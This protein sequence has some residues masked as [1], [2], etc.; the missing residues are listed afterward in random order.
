[1]PENKKLVIIEC[2]TTLSAFT[3]HFLKIGKFFGTIIVNSVCDFIINEINESTK[4]VW[5][6][7]ELINIIK[8]IIQDD[9]TK[10]PLALLY[11]MSHFNKI[12]PLSP[13]E[14]FL[15]NWLSEKRLSN[16][17]E[18]VKVIEDLF[19]EIATFG[20]KPVKIYPMAFDAENSIKFHYR[21]QSGFIRLYQ[22]Y[23]QLNLVKNFDISPNDITETI[24]EEHGQKSF[25]YEDKKILSSNIKKSLDSADCIV[26]SASDLTS[27]YYMLKNKD[28]NKGIQ[29]SKASIIVICPILSRKDM[30]SREIPL[31]KL[32]GK[33]YN[34]DSF[35][36]QMKDIC[37]AVVIDIG[38][39]DMARFGQEKGLQVVVED[40]IQIKDSYS[41][42]NSILKELDF[43]ILDISV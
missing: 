21:D 29:D 32:I 27:L 22:L 41:F 12:L 24:N 7:L 16:E 42:I 5:I 14:Q 2:G 3:E 9:L 40:L 26:I 1:M 20:N 6:P 10:S 39:V 38:D 11:S 28:V 4:N 35:F 8:G 36:D 33:S 43:N 19:S 25:N 18:Y 17:K 23:G 15:T 34:L 31:L 30:N 13:D 37:D